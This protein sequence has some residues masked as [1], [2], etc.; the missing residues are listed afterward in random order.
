MINF[1]NAYINCDPEPTNETKIINVVRHI[2]HIKKEIGVDYIGMG[3][4]YDGVD[5]VPIGKKLSMMV[6]PL[7]DKTCRTKVTKILSEKLFQN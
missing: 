7:S 1:Y 6:L 2:E 3:S 5:K 4:D